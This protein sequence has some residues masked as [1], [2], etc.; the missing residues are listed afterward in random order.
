MDECEGIFS[1]FEREVGSP[2][3]K[4]ERILELTAMLPSATVPA[5]RT[6][7]DTLRSRL[8]EIAEHHGGSVPLHGRLFAQWLHHAYPR[9]CPFPHVIGAT[10][11]MSASEWMDAM[12]L[13]S[14]EATEEEMSMLVKFEEQDVMTPEAKAEVLPWTMAEELVAGHLV[15][16][17]VSP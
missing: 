11:R 3:A 6:L 15:R 17:Q 14:A 5:P 1:H 8:G 7:P 13:D 9:E 2:T 4:V 16:P 10:N 12:D